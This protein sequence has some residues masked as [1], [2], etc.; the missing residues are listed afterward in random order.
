MTALLLLLPSTPL[1]FQGQ[2][3]SASAPF[4]Y[5]ANHDPDL[6][7]IVRKGRLEFLSQ[8]PSSSDY[9]RRSELDDPC[10]PRTFEACTLD[11]SERRLHAAAYALHRDLLQLRR[12][13]GAF[14]SQLRHGV[15]GAVLSARAFV[16]RFFTEGH[17]DD[18]LLI[19]NLGRDLT[20]PSFAEPL[21]APPASDLEWGIRWSS[22]DPKYGGRGTTEIWAKDYAD[23]ATHDPAATD[24]YFFDGECAL[25]LYPTPRTIRPDSGIR[26]R[27][28]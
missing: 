26:P 27:T 15:D 28:A 20:R 18:R 5:F 7:A 14:R 24:R 23:R 1:L 11:L 3:F 4:L 16:L 9:V 2:E 19:V 25:V 12:E 10:D 6:A 8:F 17:R 13:D 21:L 22:E